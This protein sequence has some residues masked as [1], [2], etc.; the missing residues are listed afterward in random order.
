MLNSVEGWKSF[1][2]VIS[3]VIDTLRTARLGAPNK[4]KD[5]QVFQKKLLFNRE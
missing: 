4:Q 2:I 5:F 1:L 3:V